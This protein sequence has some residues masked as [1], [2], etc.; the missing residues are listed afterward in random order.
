MHYCMRKPLRK[1]PAPCSAPQ[2][3]WPLLLGE[4]GQLSALMVLPAMA[5][6]ALGLM[7]QD[8]LDQARFRKA[9]LIVLVIAG[10]NLLRRALTV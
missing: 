5:G 4:G 1:L 10:A 2:P 9:T 3:A 8:R 7:V 6:M